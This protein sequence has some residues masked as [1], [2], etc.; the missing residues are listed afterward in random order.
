LDLCC[1]QGRHS[2][3]LS[4]EYR[5]I[6]LYGHDQSAFLINL[7]NARA[8]EQAV[9]PVVFT[10]GD[11]R[12]IPYPD[13]HF[14]LVL[15]LGNSFGY[16]ASDDGDKIVLDEIKRVLAPAGRVVLDITDGGYMRENFAERS[17]EWIDSTTFACRERQLSKDGLRLVS[18]EIV[19]D[20]IIGVIRDQF[21]QERLYSREELTDIL[22]HVGYTVSPVQNGISIEEITVTKD[23]SY[24]NEDLGMMEQRMLLKACKPTKSDCAPSDAV[25]SAVNIDEST[26][27]TR[28]TPR[29]WKLAEF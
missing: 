29:T 13:N 28:G 9:N 21:Y 16:F 26:T 24:R 19:T 23:L 27:V 22:K 4:N 20:A 12:E 15:V 3:A 6:S 10:V 17:W 8:K 5:N 2:I 7:A 18:R 14:D 11:C 1:G 25:T